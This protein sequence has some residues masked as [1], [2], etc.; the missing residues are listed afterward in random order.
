LLVFACGF[1][2]GNVFHP[3]SAVQAQPVVQVHPNTRVFEIRTYT[4]SEGKLQALHARFRDHTVALFQ[5][6]DITSVGYFMPQ[7]PPLKQN[8]LVYI[9]A[10][11]SREAAANWQAFRDDRSGRIGSGARRRRSSCHA[12]CYPLR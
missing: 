2:L 10:H 7:D 8:T 3:W 11:P 4:A 6:H 9:L 1:W 5:K 12:S